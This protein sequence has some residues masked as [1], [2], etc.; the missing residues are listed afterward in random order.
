MR[1]FPSDLDPASCLRADGVIQSDH[2]DVRA[3]AARL[4]AGVT[5]DEEYALA[6]FEWVR[7]EIGHS[8]DVNDPR[9]TVTA[10]EVLGEGVG[11]CYAKAHLLAAVLRAEG[12][13][14]AL[15]YQRLAD[16]DTFMLHGLVAVHMDGAWHRQ[17]PRG[18]KPGVRAEFSLGEERLAWPVDPEIGEIDYPELFAS[19][20][21]TVIES[22][23]R[24]DD[25][26]AFVKEGGLPT[27]L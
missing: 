22:L 4:R 16:G 26:V 23:A 17:D 12:I 8:L 20:A 1:A 21:P 14:T 7:D 10:S 3:L 6:A 11:L 24:A 25:I 13:P 19:P 2:A 5:S 27:A 18:N 15:A 9:V